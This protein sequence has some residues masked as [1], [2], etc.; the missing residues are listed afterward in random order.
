MLTPQR[1]PFPYSSGRHMLPTAKRFSA[2][3]F[4]RRVNLGLSRLSAMRLI[5]YN[6]AMTKSLEEAIEVLR[7]LPENMQDA[8]AHALIAQMQEEPER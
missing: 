8:A 4:L 6:L 7:Q 3:F 2:T 5:C 1:F